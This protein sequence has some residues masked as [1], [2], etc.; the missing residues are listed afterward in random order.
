MIIEQI[1]YF[2]AEDR[3]EEILEV[4]REVTRIRRELG[5]PSGQILVAD[6]PPDDGP[7]LVWQCGYE[8][9]SELGAAQ[10]ALMGNPRYEEMRDRLGTPVARVELEI[11]AADDVVSG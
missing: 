9:E 1:R 5:L 2:M 7:V 10:A 4:R 11:Y 3:M 6:P 8:D